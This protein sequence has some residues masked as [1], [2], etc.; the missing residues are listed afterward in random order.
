MGRTI[1]GVIMITLPRA[2]SQVNYKTSECVEKVLILSPN[3]Y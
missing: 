2:T 1:G 3:K